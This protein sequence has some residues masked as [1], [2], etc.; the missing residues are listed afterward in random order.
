V[1]G[2][3]SVTAWSLLAVGPPMLEEVLVAAL[4]RFVY[5]A[6][7][8]GRRILMAPPC[9]GAK[10]VPMSDPMLERYRKTLTESVVFAQLSPAEMD[11]IMASC[12]LV[13]VGS[14][15][16]LMSEGRKGDGLYVIL[17]GRVE[18]FLPQRSVAGVRRPSRVRLN[19]LGPGR[20]FGE[21]GLI[22]DQPSSASAEAVT[23]ARLCFLPTDDFR[24]I[25][26][27]NDRMGRIIYADLLR[28]LVSRLRSKDKELDLVMFVE[29]PR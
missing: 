23:A 29:E 25:V 7:V 13:D 14:G 28:F 21:Y 6:V 16:V 17:E 4:F 2:V 5:A 3:P 15:Q 10:S 20:C 12:R 22:D 19:T 24:R 18:F 9:G 11:L 1:V 27:G 8:P 26:N